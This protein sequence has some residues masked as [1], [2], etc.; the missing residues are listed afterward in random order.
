MARNLAEA[1]MDVTAWNRATGKARPLAGDGITV[2]EDP[3]A[4]VADAWTR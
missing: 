3:A 4:A 2:A 1:G